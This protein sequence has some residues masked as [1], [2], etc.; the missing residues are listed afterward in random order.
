MEADEIDKL[1]LGWL[2][3]R[4]GIGKIYVMVRFFDFIEISRKLMQLLAW[5]I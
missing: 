4:K 2:K 3:L 5:P 1:R